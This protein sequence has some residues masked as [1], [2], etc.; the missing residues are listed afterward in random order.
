MSGRAQEPEITP[1]LVR[2][3]GLSEEEYARCRQVL[4]RVPNHTEL[5]I[6]SAMWSEHCS[7]KSSKVHLR[8][9][10]TTGPKVVQGPGENAGVVDIGDGD[11]AVFKMESHNHP[12]F[13][14]PV[15]GAATGVGG[16]LR[17]VF[18]MGARPIAS[19]NALRFGSP[20][21]PRM[22]YLVS[23]VVHGISM[24]GNSIGV[25]TVGG[26]VTFHPSFNGNILVNAFTLGVARRDGIFLGKAEGPGNPVIYFGS[27]TGRDGIHG[28]TMASDVFESDKEARRPTVQ[29]GDPFTEK[30]LLEASLELM[31]GDFLVG[32]QD[33]GAAGLTCSTLEMAGRAGTGVV[34]DLA[35]VP[36]RE[37]GMTPYEVMLSESQE[38]M[39]MVVRRGREAEALA[40]IRKWDL[41]A[42]VIG[43][44]TSDGC[45]RILEEGRAVAVV[46]AA[47]LSDA[48]PV[49]ER[50][51]SEP[52]EFKTRRRLD[53]SSVPVPSDMGNVLDRM[54]GSPNLCSR[55]WVWRQYDH[56]VRAGTI[57]RPGADA[58]VVRVPGP[59]DRALAMSSDCNP[60]YCMLDPYLGGAHA[61]AESARNVACSGGRPLAATDCLNFGNPENP[62]IM[63]QLARA[64]EGIAEACRH[65]GTPIVSGNVSL[66][67]ETDGRA[68]APTPTIVM[69]GLLARAGLAT[70]SWFKDEGDLI[71]LLGETREELGASEYLA[72]V[73]G[74]EEGAPPGLDLA[75]EAAVQET[76]VRAIEAGIVR[77]A[78]D[79]SDGG[80]GIALAEACI[81]GCDALGTGAPLRGADVDLPAGVREDALLF[82]E[83]AS[84]VILSLREKDL[85]AL[86]QVVASLPGRRPPLRVIGRVRGA[87]LVV[88][89]GGG[90]PLV[91]RDVAHL[92]QVWHSG[93]PGLMKPERAPVNG[94]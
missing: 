34:I 9:L 61:V 70:T 59:G 82:G 10:P 40:I 1:E 5:G 29:V 18:T 76:V 57:V 41:D 53:L 16:I 22:R 92:H 74:R 46:P 45:A 80:L 48:S 55:E 35:K 71:V 36:R 8:K 31:K 69:V 42:A 20:D 87:R 56:T 47:P 6:F 12:S 23:G 81:G 15:Q 65:L 86:E 64:V 30:L 83:T 3:H 50:P 90:E 85:P 66:Y 4:G 72:L 44:V 91:A 28:A 21:A 14:E 73:H 49:Y 51:M 67:N 38:R 19:L 33:M 68:V 58:A 60:R 2:Q 13:I 11:V 27:K 43:E 32:I 17:D 39:L 84:R 79:V 7:Y 78:H 24:Y 93:F 77:S 88:R 37:T 75:L 54:L 25:P 89:A 62:G 94:R 63:W 26:E 52:P